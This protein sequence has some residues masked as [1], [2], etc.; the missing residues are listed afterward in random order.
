[1]RFPRHPMH[2]RILTHEDVLD[3]IAVSDR[4][5]Q[6]FPAHQLDRIVDDPRAAEYAPTL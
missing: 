5:A 4:L 3:L 2:P 6:V 1:M